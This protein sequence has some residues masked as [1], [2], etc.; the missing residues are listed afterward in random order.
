MPEIRLQHDG[1]KAFRVIR[2]SDQ[3]IVDTRA[4]L[5]IKAWDERW[6]QVQAAEAKRLRREQASSNVVANKQLAAN[7]TAEAQR[8]VDELCKTLLRGIELDN[9]I[10]WESLKDVSGFPVPKPSLPTAKNIPS[11]PSQAQFAPKLNWLQILVPPLRRKAIDASIE[12]FVAAE[13]VWKLAEE[14]VR[15]ENANVIEVHKRSLVQWE[16]DRVNYLRVQEAQ[17]AEVESR[18]EGY[19]NKEV[20]AL[21]EYW[22]AGV[23]P[24]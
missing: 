15:K 6:K 9:R 17:H 22:E 21:N 11:A 14:A 23:K 18:K 5:Q 7:K 24:V 1:L 4:R 16:A 2:H 8:S 20:T 12:R 10:D 19:F 3:S 13:G